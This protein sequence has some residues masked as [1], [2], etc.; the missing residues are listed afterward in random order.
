VWP[1]A[2]VA[3]SPSLGGRVAVQASYMS[4]AD[5]TN[6]DKNYIFPA[7]EQDSDAADTIAEAA[8]ATAFAVTPHLS[9]DR[10]VSHILTDSRS[11]LTPEETLFFA[12]RTESGDG[13]RYIESLYER[14]VR[15]FVVEQLS[16]DTE[17]KYSGC[18][19][20]V[21]T[22][23]ITALQALART[24]VRTLRGP[25]RGPVMT[26]LAQAVAGLPR[27]LRRRTRGRARRSSTSAEHR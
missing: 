6:W 8:P 20:Y 26:G 10:A 4:A 11:L 23:S 9:H 18:N 25:Q 24:L 13:H 5:S 14:G 22:S 12:I 3:A 15:S 17:A 1:R 16:S 2:L 27:E 7:T 19:W 21:V